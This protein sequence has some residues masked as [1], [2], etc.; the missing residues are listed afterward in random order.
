MALAAVGRLYRLGTALRAALRGAQGRA[1]ERARHHLAAVIA[2]QRGLAAKVGQFLATSQAD[3]EAAQ[4]DLPPMEL[5]AAQAV[6]DGAWQR[7]HRAVLADLQPASHAASLGQVHQARLINGDTV[8]I[9]VQYPDIGQAVHD[10]LGILR[11]LPRV[12]PA[13]RWGFDLDGYKEC[14]RTTLANECDYLH[15]A[16]SQQRYREAW[17]A[18]G[19]QRVMIPAIHREWCR[20]T[21]LVEEWLPGMA[22]AE[23][24]QQPVESRRAAA[25]ALLDH[26]LTMLVQSGLVHADLHPGNIGYCSDD[27][28]ADLVLYDFGC[29][30]TVPASA[31]RALLVLIDA[32]HEQAAIA[33]ADCLVELGFDRA[34]LDHIS[35][36]LPAV[37]QVL[38][39]PFLVDR[40]FDLEQWHVG[41]RIQRIL[42]DYSWWFRS[43]GAP[44]F[45][46]IMRAV[47][48]LCRHLRELAVPLNWRR[49]LRQVRDRHEQ[50]LPPLTLAPRGGEVTC[51]DLA[52]HLRIIVRR[53]LLV[54][55]DLRMPATVLNDIHSVIDSDVEAK[56]AERGLNLDRI[57]AT[58]IAAGYPPGVL[59]ELDDEER[60][61][62]VRLE[63]A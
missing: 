30:S 60:H 8:A 52:R 55:V 17:H 28:G 5:T 19:D 21:V 1:P 4:A 51:H 10:E 27:G 47:H 53:G 46:L 6:L 2:E 20:E 49:A 3:Y 50:G 40:P 12:G 15:E 58:A 23:F 24:R 25:E 39:E 34:K 59:F 29:V 33:P 57:V 35:D 36:Q 7:D 11:L 32:L 22:L 56:I 18:V 63:A 26:V 37:C 62:T 54:S 38:L 16:A 31:R 48:G 42:A 44:S 14:L 41:E 61:I 45:L 9:K 13:R 43:A